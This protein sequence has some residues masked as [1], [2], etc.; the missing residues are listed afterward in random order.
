MPPPPATELPGGLTLY[1]STPLFNELTTPAALRS[2]HC[3]KAGVWGRI[4]LLKGRLHY[5]VADPRRSAAS[6][7]LTTDGPTGII[8]PTIIHHVEPIGEVEFQVE[9]WK[10]D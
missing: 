8:E 2:D 1:R 7:E 5:C 4:R 10:A 3:T 6:L 9:F